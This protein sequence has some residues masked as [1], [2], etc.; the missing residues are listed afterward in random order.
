MCGHQNMGVDFS[1]VQVISKDLRQ[2]TSIKM[3]P[4]V[5]SHFDVLCVA[6]NWHICRDQRPMPGRPTTTVAQTVVTTD[7]G[8]CLR[9]KL[10]SRRHRPLGRCQGCSC[11]HPK[12]EK[13][14]PRR[15]L[16][17]CQAGREE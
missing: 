4:K 12:P 11:F 1:I 6:P 5:T 13:A 2:R 8:E 15:F 10:P 9:V 17:D 3:K 14:P 7:P 16:Q